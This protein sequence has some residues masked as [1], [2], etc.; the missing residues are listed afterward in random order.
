M[1][2]ETLYY[3][4]ARQILWQKRKKCKRANTQFQ[5]LSLPKWSLKLHGFADIPLFLAASVSLHPLQPSALMD[6]FYCNIMQVQCFKPLT[7]IKWPV[8]IGPCF[9][10]KVTVE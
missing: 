3:L 6:N 10:A 2:S 4:Y 8:F 9:S 5:T 7:E 1:D